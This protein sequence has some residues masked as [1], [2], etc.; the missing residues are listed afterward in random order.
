VWW[1]WREMEHKQYTS[2]TIPVVAPM[3]V[4]KFTPCADAWWD[5]LDGKLILSQY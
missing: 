1:E 4:R 2:K 3:M 5:S